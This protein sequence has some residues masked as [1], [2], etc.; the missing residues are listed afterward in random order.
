MYLFY[1]RDGTVL[2]TTSV[3]QI[4]YI[5]ESYGVQME[6]FCEDL[7]RAMEIVDEVIE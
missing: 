2:G 7:D 4:P 6:T 1:L 5:R 3:W